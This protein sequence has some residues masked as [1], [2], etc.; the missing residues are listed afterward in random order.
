MPGIDK[1]CCLTLFVLSLY[2]SVRGKS[3]TEKIMKNFFKKVGLTTVTVIGVFGLASCGTTR[4][5]LVIPH[6]VSSAS[7]VTVDD[8]NLSKGDYDVLK[9]ITESAS[10]ICEYNGSSI[11]ISSDDEFSYTFTL[12]SSGWSLSRFQG[13]AS[14]GYFTSDL[15]NHP[16]EIPNGEEFARR[17]A[18]S[19]IIRAAK[20]Y[21]A[22]GV[23][24]PVVISIANDIGRN[25]VEYISTVSAKLISIKSTR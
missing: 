22:D 6:S 8:L 11:K 23:I 3:G 14:L 24:E 12:S 20:D 21:Q 15:E 17:V 13:A 7:A 10:V 5:Y 18:M 16:S 4:N 25:K 2:R 9:S 19:R 1:H